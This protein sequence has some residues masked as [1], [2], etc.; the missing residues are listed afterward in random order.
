MLNQ[1]EAEFH[2]DKKVLVH[3]TMFGWAPITPNRSCPA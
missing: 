1:K 3:A 2:K